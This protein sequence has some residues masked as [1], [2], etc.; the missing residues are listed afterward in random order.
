MGE[1]ISEAAAADHIVDKGVT[2]GGHIGV[3]PD[4]VGGLRMGSGII[5]CGRRGKGVEPALYLFGEGPGLCVAVGEAADGADHVECVGER[6]Y[7]ADPYGVA[8][9][10]GLDLLPV[11][12]FPVGEDEVGFECVDRSR[13]EVLCPADAGFC[14]KPGGRMDT[15]FGNA[16]DF[17][18]EAKCV[19]ELC[20]GRNQRYD[21]HVCS[22]KTSC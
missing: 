12:L 10:E 4:K 21:S 5:G 1:S 14:T 3:A 19:E 6:S 7:V 20:L 11:V 18:F 22:M 16:D 9:G 8:G 13:M 15:K 17:V 2:S